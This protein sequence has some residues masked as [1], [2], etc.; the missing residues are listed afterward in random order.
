VSLSKHIKW[1]TIDDYSARA[2]MEYKGTKAS[3]E[4]HFNGKG[5]FKKIVAMRYQD[6]N[7]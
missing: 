6:S 5:N 2:T 7:A 3:R 1:E 4:F